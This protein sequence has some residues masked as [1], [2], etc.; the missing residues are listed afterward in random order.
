MLG[1]DA[2]NVLIKLLIL[3]NTFK[4]WNSILKLPVTTTLVDAN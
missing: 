3:S 1:I 4:D 2:R